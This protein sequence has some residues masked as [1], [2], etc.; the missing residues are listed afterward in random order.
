M[1]KI[2]IGIFIGG[3]ASFIF[4]KLRPSIHS[5]EETPE[6]ELINLG[7]SLK[8]SDRYKEYRIPYKNLPRSNRKYKE[9]KEKKLT[10]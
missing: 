10:N 4:R 7:D 1:K 2:L 6:R 5:E 3:I 9:R 8:Q